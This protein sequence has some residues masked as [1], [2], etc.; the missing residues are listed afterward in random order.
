MAALWVYSDGEW[1][2]VTLTDMRFSLRDKPGAAALGRSTGANHDGAADPVVLVRVHR[3]DAPW[4]LLAAPHA[5]VRVNGSPVFGIRLL[6][7]RDE[8]RLNRQQWYFTSERLIRPELFPGPEGTCCARCR[9]VIDI[10][11]VAVRCGCSLWFHHT[12][13]YGCWQYADR[14]CGCEAPTTIDADFKWSPEGL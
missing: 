11:T 4:A 2:V 8:V 13:E 12:E 1:G 6:A 3:E 14:C 9:E 7:D 10:G 5:N